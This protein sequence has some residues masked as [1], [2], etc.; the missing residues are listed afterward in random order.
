[1]KPYHILELEKD[2]ETYGIYF[3]AYELAAIESLTLLKAEEPEK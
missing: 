1:V 2:G 3:P